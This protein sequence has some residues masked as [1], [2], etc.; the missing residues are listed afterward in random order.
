MDEND[1]PSAPHEVRSR[2]REHRDP[3][4]RAVTLAGYDLE[5]VPS[6]IHRLGKDWGSLA[7]RNQKSETLRKGRAVV[8]LAVLPTIIGLFAPG[9]WQW[10]MNIPRLLAGH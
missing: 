5:N 2:S 1:A 6:D 7:I 4:L 9:I 10:L 3:V 8:V